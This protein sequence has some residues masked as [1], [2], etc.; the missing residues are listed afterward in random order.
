MFRRFLLTS[1]WKKHNQ[2]ISAHGFEPRTFCMLSRRDNQL[3][4]AD[5]AA[6]SSKK[7]GY[8][9]MLLVAKPSL[10][11]S[12]ASSVGRS[13]SGTVPTCMISR[14][15]HQLHHA[16]RTGRSSE[17]R[18]YI[19]GCWLQSGR[20]PLGPRPSSSPSPR[21]WDSLLPAQSQP[22]RRGETPTPP[23]GLLSA[24]ALLQK[25]KKTEKDAS[26]HCT[27]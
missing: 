22:K 9:L 13:P 7:R 17:K 1:L 14:R 20:L 24:A 3:H 19:L 6:R 15:D 26:P 4:H 25:S 18:A 12:I 8:V 11:Q 5:R 10:A 16:H 21:A 23:K 27:L 2:K